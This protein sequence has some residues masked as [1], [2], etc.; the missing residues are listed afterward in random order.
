M[1]RLRRRWC[2]WRGHPRADWSPIV[3]WYSDPDI[4]NMDGSITRGTE[5]VIRAWRC[6]LHD[7]TPDEC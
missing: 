3:F 5:I 1:K 6:A 4:L 7:R 2:A